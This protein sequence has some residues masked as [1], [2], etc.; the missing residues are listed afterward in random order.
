MI[1]RKF[2]VRHR[3]VYPDGNISEIRRLYYDSKRDAIETA[4]DMESNGHHAEWCLSAD[5]SKMSTKLNDIDGLEDKPH[6]KTA[7][8]HQSSHL[9]RMMGNLVGNIKRKL[10]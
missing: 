6:I 7:A 8:G 1:I 2:V 3:Y 5:D 4:K 9:W 10:F